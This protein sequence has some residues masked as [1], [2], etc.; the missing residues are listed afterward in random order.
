MLIKTHKIYVF[1]LKISF[2]NFILKN[3]FILFNIYIYI[4]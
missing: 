1:D 3:N 2:I 4:S